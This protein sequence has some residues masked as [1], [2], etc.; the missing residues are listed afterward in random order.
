[1]MIGYA[2]DGESLLVSPDGAD[3]HIRLTRVDKKRCDEFILCHGRNITVEDMRRFLPHWGSLEWQPSR[4]GVG[5]SKAIVANDGRFRVTLVMP[6]ACTLS[7]SQ[8]I[9]Q[10]EEFMSTT[11]AKDATS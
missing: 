7:D 5:P 1:M 11:H 2:P 4:K 3:W 10:F 8:I 6:E 9:A